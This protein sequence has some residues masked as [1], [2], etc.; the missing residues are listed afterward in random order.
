[1]Y[2]DCLFWML[3][4]TSLM[5]ILYDMANKRTKHKH[6]YYGSHFYGRM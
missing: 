5:Y 1:M 3:F 6:K 2:F 4:E